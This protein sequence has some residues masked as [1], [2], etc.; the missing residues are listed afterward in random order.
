MKDH[1]RL[2]VALEQ[3]NHQQR[4]L[5]DLNKQYADFYKHSA[6]ELLGQWNWAN[7]VIKN[8]LDKLQVVCDHN[9]ELSDKV[10]A[11]EGGL[12]DPIKY[13]QQIPDHRWHNPKKKTREIEL[14]NGNKIVVQ[15]KGYEWV[16]VLDYQTAKPKEIIKF[17]T[18]MSAC[19]TDKQRQVCKFYYDKDM[20]SYG[21]FQK[22]ADYLYPDDKYG[23]QKV[24]SVINTIE[25]NMMTVIEDSIT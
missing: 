25:K 24:R 11:Y 13:P 19:K 1:D 14:P 23:R 21:S 4:K 8:L 9:Q 17:E 6:Y 7:E 16:N 5:T 20:D 22:V 15:A 3:Q 18:I 10:I 12:K 2:I